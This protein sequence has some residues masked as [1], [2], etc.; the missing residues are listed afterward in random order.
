MSS[1]ERFDIVPTMRRLPMWLT[2]GNLTRTALVGI[3]MGQEGE[4]KW[5]V[6]RTHML[7]GTLKDERH[8]MNQPVSDKPALRIRDR[9][10]STGR[11]N[12]YERTYEI[13]DEQ[14]QCVTARCDLIGKAAL[15]AQEIVTQEG[16]RWRLVPNRKIMPSL[17][18]LSDP[19]GK[20]QWQFRHKMWGKMINPLHKTLMAVLDG[21]SREQMQLVD[22][23]GAKLPVVLGLEWGKYALVKGDQPLA[24]LTSLPRKEPPKGKGLMGAFRRFLNSSDKALVSVTATHPLPAPA[25]LALYLLYKEFTDVSASG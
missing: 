8:Q 23:H 16:Q 20:L 15:K 10:D 9:Y 21:E 3:H 25:A 2:P 14:L 24:T 6:V 11:A 19:Q 17:W 5:I 13:F 22:L 7:H 12:G 18:L 4:R 1:F